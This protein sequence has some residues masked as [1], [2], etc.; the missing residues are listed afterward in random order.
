MV[1]L[2]SLLH[3]AKTLFLKVLHI[4][5]RLIVILMQVI[6][7]L[8]MLVNKFLMVTG[9]GTIL[10]CMSRGLEL[11]VVVNTSLM[12][13]HQ[14]ELAD[15]MAKENYCL[16][17]DCEYQIRSNSRHL[18]ETFRTWTAGSQKKYETQQNG[19]TRV[20]DQLMNFT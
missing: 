3:N 7:L 17:T 11:I 5:L 16:G 9:S 18:L 4:V 10:E 19:I 12:H 2:H 6:W 20:L 1:R 15:A 13:N 8:A 14:K